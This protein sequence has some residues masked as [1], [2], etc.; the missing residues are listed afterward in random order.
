VTSSLAAANGVSP[1]PSAAICPRPAAGPAE[2]DLPARPPSHQGGSPLGR[3]LKSQFPS[4]RLRKPGKNRGG[5]WP[6]SP[7]PPLSLAPQK[8]VGERNGQ[9][10]LPA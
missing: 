6:P 2:R 1:K 5:S 10:A 3:G 8:G 9:V 4:L 7:E